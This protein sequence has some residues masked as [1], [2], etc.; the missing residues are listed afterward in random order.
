[1]NIKSEEAVGR[2]PLEAECKFRVENASHLEAKLAGIQAKFVARE[3]HCDTYLRHPARDF[4]VT[5]EAL[6]IREIDGQPHVTYKGPRQPGPIKIRPEIELPLGPNTAAPWLQIWEHLGFQ[7][8]AK[9]EKHRDVYQVEQ[10]GRSLTV[11]IDRVEKLGVF[12]EIERVVDSSEEA[13]AAQRDILAL[14]ERL[15]LDRIER[16]SYLGLLLEK[17]TDKA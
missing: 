17:S 8:A 1:L 6:R 14:A 15:G 10:E 11:T 13:E 9:V 16:R 7:V 12:A 4:R 2:E 5:D 3:H